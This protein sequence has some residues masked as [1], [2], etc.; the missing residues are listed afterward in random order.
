MPAIKFLRPVRLQ[1]PLV[2]SVRASGQVPKWIDMV[3]LQVVQTETRRFAKLTQRRVNY[4][5]RRHAQCTALHKI[6]VLET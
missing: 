5:G 1:M 2:V 6:G 3:K 4:R